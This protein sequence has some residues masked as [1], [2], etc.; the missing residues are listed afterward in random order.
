MPTLRVAVE[1]LGY[2]GLVELPSPATTLAQLRSTLAQTFDYDSLPPH[3]QFLSPAGA[4]IGM[5]AEPATLAWSLRPSITLL[6]T[7][8]SPLVGAC[9]TVRPRFSFLDAAPF[10]CPPSPLPLTPTYFPHSCAHAP[11]SSPRLGAL[12]E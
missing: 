1:G 5:R 4:T 7:S 2:V 12:V 11:L 10:C 3:Y 9:F 8:E 6:P